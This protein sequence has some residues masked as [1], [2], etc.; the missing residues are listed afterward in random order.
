MIKL[1]SIG[2]VLLAITLLIIGV[3]GVNA[4]SGPP[5]ANAVIL[6]IRH[7]EK[8]DTGSGLTPA[9]QKRAQAYVRY[10][11][12]F[13]LDSKPRVPDYL[14]ASADSKHSQRP[15]LTITPLSSAL[16]LTIDTRFHDKD[17]DSAAQAL[18]SQPTGKTILICWHHEEISDLL[19]SL[20]ADP[21]LLLPNGEWPAS[22]YDWMIVLR[23][24][25]NGHLLLGQCRRINERLMPGDS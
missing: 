3:C 5:L 21:N 22:V 8:P 7:A 14:M 1:R 10:F 20:G 23:Y 17:T 13:H 15:R 2:S 19:T 4:A 16:N 9:G 24:D 25:S 6:I 12:T 18:E 11:Q